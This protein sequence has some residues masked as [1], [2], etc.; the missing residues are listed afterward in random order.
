[1]MKQPHRFRLGLCLILPWMHDASAQPDVA[2]PPA[3][4]REGQRS[5]DRRPDEPFTVDLFGTPVQLT[6]GWEY[7]DER[8]KNFDLD[9]SRARDRR[10][11]EHEI[12]LEARM[13]LGA[14]TQAFVQ[15]GGVHD[16]R[17]TQ[18]TPGKES[19]RALQ[20]EQM[21]LQRDRIGGTP[22]SLQIGRV[23]LLDRRAW[24]WD[25]DLDA[26]RARYA[27]GQWR[28]DT[29]IAREVAK[30]SSA[31]RAIDPAAKGVTR[32]FGQL[33][34]PWAQRHAVDAFWLV[35]TDGSSRPAPGA[36]F[37]DEDRTDPSDLR[38]RWIGARASGEWRIADGPRL[39]YWADLARLSGREHLSSFKEQDDGSFTADGASRRRVS[40]SAFDIGATG[41]LPLPLRPSLSVGFARGSSGFRQTGL[42]ENKTRI[43]GV[44]RVQRYGEL[45]RPELSNLS[46]ATLGTGVRLLDNSS[47]ELVAHR[48]R[49]VR[50]SSSIAGSR[51]SAEPQGTSRQVGR[52]V[53]LLFAARQWQQVEV[54]VRASHFKPGA[55]FA[56]AERKPARAVEFGIAVNF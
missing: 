36:V 44:K 4:Q 45:L 31:E 9:D 48:Y 14:D 33:T 53:N 42:Q 12:K 29:G 56:P 37:A 19:T 43:G 34:W 51:L 50:A 26:I 21:W 8:R 3:P 46:V 20:R 54:T 40:G 18:G 38:A 2:A 41:S 15:I 7:S 6:G 24:W 23:P 13:Q 25:E 10:T 16:S 22:W 39:A 35:Q 1:M 30:R 55:A 11:R 32:W 27:T 47:L 28:L 5:D 52:E 49:Q 17:R